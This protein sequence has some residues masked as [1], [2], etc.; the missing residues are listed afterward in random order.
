MYAD[1]IVDISHKAVDRTFS[2]RI[3]DGLED[4]VS[5]GTPVK[6]PFGNGNRTRKGYVISI[7]ETTPWEPDK[8]KEILMKKCIK[9]NFG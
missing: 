3:P 5:V 7:S 8:V 1:V 6:V 4:I 9:P 2:Y